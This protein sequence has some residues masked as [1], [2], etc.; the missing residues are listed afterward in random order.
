MHN[1]SITA[2]PIEYKIQDR[3]ETKRTNTNF[4]KEIG[5][6][7]IGNEVAIGSYNIIQAYGGV[8]IKDKVTLSA[9]ISIYSYSH[10]PFDKNNLSKVTYANAMVNSES[11]S[12]MESPIVIE[13]G[14]WLGLNVIVFGGTID[15]NSFV[16]ANSVV[17]NDLKE[18]SY[19]NGNPAIKIKNRFKY[20]TK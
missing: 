15:K 5:S 14:V 2:R 20:E 9:R 12:C 1:S 8:I 18:N 11:I 6:L 7:N 4:D 3:I 13:E 17:L 10:M 19:A 16:T